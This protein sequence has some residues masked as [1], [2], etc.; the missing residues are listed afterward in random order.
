[1]SPGQA[2]LNEEEAGGR[3]CNDR[4]IPPVVQCVCLKMR[5]AWKTQATGSTGGLS[6]FI[7]KVE[8]MLVVNL[9]HR[10]LWDLGGQGEIQAG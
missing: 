6:I 5:D 2:E 1:M 10:F 3:L 9:T 4:H 8:A 7:H